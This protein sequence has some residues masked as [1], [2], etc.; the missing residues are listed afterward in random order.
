MEHSFSVCTHI[1]SS[2][3][4]ALSTERDHLKITTEQILLTHRSDTNMAGG[5]VCPS[6]IL[7]SDSIQKIIVYLKCST[8]IM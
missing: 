2:P 5:A 1:L 6:F 3:L 8:R 4:L 7:N